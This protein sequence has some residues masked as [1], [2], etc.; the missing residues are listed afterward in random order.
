MLTSLRPAMF[1]DKEQNQLFQNKI[2]SILH[3]I[4]LFEKGWEEYMDQSCSDESEEIHHHKNKNNSLD[5]TDID[6]LFQK[7]KNKSLGNSNYANLL[8]II[9]SLSMIPNDENGNKIWNE[10]KELLADFQ[11]KN[12]SG[13]SFSFFTC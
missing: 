12:Y 13:L 6:N 3:Q 7:I 9:Q 5:L 11:G 10:L 2:Q 1:F 4:E 8:S